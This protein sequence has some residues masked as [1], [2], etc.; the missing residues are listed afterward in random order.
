MYSIRIGFDL[1]APPPRFSHPPYSSD[2]LK[3]RS[4]VRLGIAGLKVILPLIIAAFPL[5]VNSAV[6]EFHPERL[7]SIAESE[8]EPTDSE[9]TWPSTQPPASLSRR[10][11]YDLRRVQTTVSLSLQDGFSPSE[12]LVIWDID[13]TLVRGGSGSVDPPATPFSAMPY[14]VDTVQQLAQR[15]VEL[16]LIS[17]AGGRASRKKLDDIGLLNI[18]KM[19]ATNAAPSRR[20]TLKRRDGLGD[21]SF[22][23]FGDGPLVGALLERGEREPAY[24]AKIVAAHR[25]MLELG[26]LWRIRQII[27]VDDK[28]SCIDRLIREYATF[29]LFTER[30][31]QIKCLHY[32]PA[33]SLGLRESLR[34]D[35]L[36][37]L[38]ERYCEL[39]HS[40]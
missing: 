32:R 35:P 30:L 19:D 15:Q 3:L 29:R 40:S 31:V 8:L 12:I 4:R 17:A 28:R 7:A 2:A 26:A 23:Y 21:E 25:A 18:L 10:E 16:L 9:L 39:A 33:S 1:S 36:G 38:L 11:I 27:F 22:I 6:P 20:I 37:A 24:H 14:A 13:N 34:E 5:W